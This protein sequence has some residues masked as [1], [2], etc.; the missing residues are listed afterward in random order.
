MTAPALAIWQRIGREADP[1]TNNR[2]LLDRARVALARDDPVAA[3]ALLGGVVAPRNAARLPLRL[4]LLN[5]DLLTAQ[6]WLRQR[7]F[8]DA[9][10]NAAQVLNAL[11]ASPLRQY[12]IPLEAD[13]LLR[14]G[15]AQHGLR[16]LA[17][18]RVNLE[19][20]VELR[21]SVDA[22]TSPALAEAQLALAACLREM[23]E[24]RA[25][26]ALEQ[27]GRAV[28]ASHSRIGGQFARVVSVTAR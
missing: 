5:A 21:A 17:A 23:D 28:L 6:A 26:A 18:A 13:A 25:A 20:S 2:F 15:I 19:R 27:R 14:L 9:S 22:S 12:Y 8:E 7:R 10:R 16:D 4:E 3:L 24:R 11:Q 1:V